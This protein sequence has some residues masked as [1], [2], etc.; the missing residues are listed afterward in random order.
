MD[1][2][3][4]MGRLDFRHESQRMITLDQRSSTTFAAAGHRMPHGGEWRADL[5]R[6]PGS[7][8]I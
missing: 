2:M 1:G 8:R 5:D 4:E 7:R 6:V 3:P